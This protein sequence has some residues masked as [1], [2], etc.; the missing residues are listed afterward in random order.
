MT[1]VNTNISLLIL[2]KCSR[3]FRLT[4]FRYF[5]SKLI[6]DLLEAKC[7][8]LQLLLPEIVQ[9]LQVK[10]TCGSVRQLTIT[11]SNGNAAM[12]D[13][14]TNLYSQHVFFFYKSW[15]VQFSEGWVDKAWSPNMSLFLEWNLETL[16]LL[17]LNDALFALHQ[18]GSSC[19][20]LMQNI[21]IM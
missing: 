7:G 9:N 12:S 18:L 17:C 2:N 3:K 11:E 6:T 19:R 21:D 16:I 14:V 4:Y 13:I 10:L 20:E 5:T 15:G 8:N 1:K